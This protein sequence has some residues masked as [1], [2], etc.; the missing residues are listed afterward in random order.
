MQEGLLCMWGWKTTTLVI[1]LFES[2]TQE[3]HSEV[4][5]VNSSSYDFT[6]KFSLTFPGQE[7]WGVGG[8]E[9]ELEA[10]VKFGNRRV[11]YSMGRRCCKRRKEWEISPLKFWVRKWEWKYYSFSHRDWIQLLVSS[12]GGT[13]ASY[14]NSRL[15]G[16]QIDGVEKCVDRRSGTRGTRLK[17]DQSECC[18]QYWS[19]HKCYFHP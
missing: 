4:F 3:F 17:T 14:A 8:G 18:G 15:Y 12:G 7:F 6:S 11:R 5:C 2:T 13:L 19:R 10:R 9:T 16:R 1:C